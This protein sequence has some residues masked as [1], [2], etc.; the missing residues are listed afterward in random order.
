MMK[1]P[2]RKI[3]CDYRTKDFPTN[4]RWLTIKKVIAIESHIANPPQRGVISLCISRVLSC[5]KAPVL[6]ANFLMK[7]VIRNANTADNVI[8]KRYSRTV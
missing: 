8:V 6:K 7:G 5:R 2:A 4:G 3:P 1:V